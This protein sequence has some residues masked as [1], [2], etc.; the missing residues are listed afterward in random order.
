MESQ[1][2]NVRKAFEFANAIS[3]LEGWEPNHFALSTQ[4][5][6]IAGTLSFDNAVEKIIF[7]ATSHGKRN[8]DAESG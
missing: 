3:R 5:A 7:A 1:G 2:P 6:V 8:E 4:E